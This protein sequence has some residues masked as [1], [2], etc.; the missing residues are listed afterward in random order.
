MTVSLG[1]KYASKR[2]RLTS[3]EKSC[4]SRGRLSSFAGGS[5][6]VLEEIEEHWTRW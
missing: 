2:F 4:R 6:K 1:R 5:A 3:W